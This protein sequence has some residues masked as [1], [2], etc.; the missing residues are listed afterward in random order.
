LVLGNA[1]KL[2]FFCLQTLSWVQGFRVQR[3][4]LSQKPTAACDEPSRVKP[5]NF[6][7]R[8]SL[9]GI[10][11]LFLLNSLFDILRFAAEFNPEP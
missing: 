11:S 6:E 7:Y 2:I 9:V 10:A 4:G 3:T 1:Y 8:I 5:P